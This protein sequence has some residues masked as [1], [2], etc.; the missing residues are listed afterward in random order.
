ME[1]QGDGVLV[2]GFARTG[3]RFWGAVRRLEAV[4]GVADGASQPHTKQKRSCTS[5]RPRDG[6]GGL[7][8]FGEIGV[9][10][11]QKSEGSKAGPIPAGGG[12]WVCSGGEK[13]FPMEGQQTLRGRSQALPGGMA[14]TASGLSEP[15][16]P[17]R[18]LSRRCSRSC[19]D[20]ALRRLL[21]SASSFALHGFKRH[22]IKAA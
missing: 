22:E 10:C 8:T 11:S 5:H 21:A 16:P 13:P 14:W 9:R 15:S 6:Q 1:P 2:P 20:L 3:L 18:F 19:P 17:E 12:G 7:N 4:R